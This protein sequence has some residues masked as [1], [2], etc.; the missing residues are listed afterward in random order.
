MKGKSSDFSK[1]KES[2]KSLGHEF[3]DSVYYLCLA[4]IVVVSWSLT[5]EVAGSYLNIIF[6]VTE[7]AEFSEN[8]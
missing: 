2:E 6:L 1:F 7:F 8:I 4:G 3:K 5:Q